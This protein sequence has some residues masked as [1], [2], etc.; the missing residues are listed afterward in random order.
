MIIVHRPHV[1]YGSFCSSP[2][3]LARV[4]PRASRLRRGEL[5][6]VALTAEWAKFRARGIHKNIWLWVVVPVTGVA[7]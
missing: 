7:G 4:R 2:V 6:N 5:A 3:G 1:P